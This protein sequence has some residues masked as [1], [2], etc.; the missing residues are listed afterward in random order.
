[1]PSRVVDAVAADDADARLRRDGR[2]P[3]EDSAQDVQRQCVAGESDDVQ[4]EDRARAHSVHVA[5]R[6]G[7][8]DRA[9]LVGIVH[10]RR[11]VVDGG[12]QRLIGRQAVHRRVVGGR[13][14][15]EHVRIAGY[16]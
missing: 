9:K 5:Q 2:A 1:M 10:N 14:A 6:V 7:R 4:R 8:G 16:R 11:D 13:G 3:F 15:D 12:H